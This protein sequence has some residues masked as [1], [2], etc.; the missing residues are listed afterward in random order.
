MRR[1][2][3]VTAAIGLAG[4]LSLPAQADPV[5]RTVVWQC[6]VEGEVVDFV[7]APEKARH[8]IVQADS[9]AGAVFEELFGE[10]CHVE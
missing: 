4:T 8:G 6:V 10:D 5:P 9:K 3:L 2:I 7:V 1:I